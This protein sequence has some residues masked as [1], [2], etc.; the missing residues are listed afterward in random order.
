MPKRVSDA[1]AA[2]L[3]FNP[4]LPVEFF[5][6]S[7]LPPVDWLPSGISPVDSLLGGGLPVGRVIEFYGPDGIGKTTLALHF[8]PEI[9]IDVERTAEKRW[10]EMFSP[11]TEIVRPKS[12]ERMVSEVVWDTI[13]AAAASKIRLVAVDSLGAMV[14]TAE[15]EEKGGQAV[16]A[17]D[18]SKNLRRII[19][20]LDPTTLL[21]INQA[22]SIMGSQVPGAFNSPGGRFF[23]HVCSQR[24]EMRWRGEWVKYSDEKIGHAARLYLKKNKVGRAEMDAT[25]YL[26]YMMGLFETEEALKDEYKRRKKEG[27]ALRAAPTLP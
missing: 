17:R 20:L 12:G 7:E 24:M 16:L 8:K 21:V 26:G 5:E 13:E 11:R 14:S 19:P 6:P 9:Y 10:F 3:T 2:M 15:M 22:R 27:L 1:K 23:Y 25:I 4:K 18:V